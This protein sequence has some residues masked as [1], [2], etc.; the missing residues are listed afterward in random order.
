MRR[1][2][3]LLV[4]DEKEALHALELMLQESGYEV[5]ATASAEEGLRYL[6]AIHPHLLMVDFKLPAMS[7]ID[8]LEIAR[9]EDPHVP[10][11]VV[12]GLT[13]R[14]EEIEAS[15]KKLRIFELIRK[16]VGIQKLRDAVQAALE[17][18]GGT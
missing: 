10:A 6:R 11:L 9:A 8:F 7:G 1:K 14:I 12:T 15:C 3:I 2:R 18:S 5:Y 13:Q 16:P 17:T 4:D